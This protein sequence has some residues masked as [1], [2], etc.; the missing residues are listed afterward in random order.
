MSNWPDRLRVAPIREW[1]GE[2]T[3]NRTA[4]QFRAGLRDTL[5]AHLSEEL[6]EEGDEDV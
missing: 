1:P 4:S 6:D 5:D 3:R 2:L